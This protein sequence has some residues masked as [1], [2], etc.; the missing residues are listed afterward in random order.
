MFVRQGLKLSAVGVG[1]G[2]VVALGATRLMASLLFGVAAT[3]VVTYAT[4]VGVIVAAA[5]LASYL[6]ARRASAI[7]PIETLK[8]E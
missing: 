2:L 5:A 8:A 4:A 3:D 1:V 7:D 6:P